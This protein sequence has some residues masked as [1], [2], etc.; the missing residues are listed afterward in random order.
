M[1]PNDLPPTARLLA[2]I[3]QGA[4]VDDYD[5]QVLVQLYDI[6]YS[7][8]ANCLT[9]AQQYS[10][11]A[12]HKEITVSD[13]KLAIETRASIDFPKKPSR[14]T[15]VELAQK[16]NSIPLPL[17]PEK[18]GIRLPPERHCLIK[19]NISIIPKVFLVLT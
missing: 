2:L 4:N 5:P 16:K 11:H 18:F 10:E 12:G 15:L 19:P 14:Q 7:Y 3:L 8:I 17:V 9:E 13:I 6:A 1:D